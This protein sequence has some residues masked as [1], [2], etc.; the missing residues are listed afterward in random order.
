MDYPLLEDDYD[1]AAPQIKCHAD[2]I[3]ARIF[4]VPAIDPDGDDVRVLA[5]DKATAAYCGR[6]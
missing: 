4:L 6:K 1:V 3:G 5:F 2:K